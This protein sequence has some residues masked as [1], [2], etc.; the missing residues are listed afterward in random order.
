MSL[1]FN[2][3]G[4]SS[5]VFAPSPDLGTDAFKA[6]GDGKYDIRFDFGLTPSTAFSASDYLTYT[7][8]GIPTLTSSNFQFLSKPA[9][10]HGPF[11]AAIHVLGIGIMD[12][13]D[14]SDSGWV[15]GQPS[16]L[17]VVPEPASGLLLLLAAAFGFIP[18]T[19]FLSR[20]A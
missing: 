5:G 11:Y 10:G 4:G 3:T 20:G 14:L 12:V 15:A 18:R 13:N 8:T 16:T 6:D 9:G 19:R 2:N 1:I 7:I 17:V